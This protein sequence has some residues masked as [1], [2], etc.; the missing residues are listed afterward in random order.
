ME[1]KAGR[2]LFNII[3]LALSLPFVRSRK[4]EGCVS[5]T[6]YDGMLAFPSKETYPPLSQIQ[7]VNTY[8]ISPQ[9]QRGRLFHVLCGCHMIQDILSTR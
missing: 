1:L 4:R 5:A 8:P 3:S 6:F 2:Q 7:D 9:T